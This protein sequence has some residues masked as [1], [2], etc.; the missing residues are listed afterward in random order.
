MNGVVLGWVLIGIGA[1]A[2]LFGVVGGILTMF[3]TIMHPPP[4]KPES[5]GIP[6]LP[7]EFIKVLTEF[8]KT[9]IQA[10]VWLALIIIGIALV[11][12]GGTMIK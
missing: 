4:G 12:W 7:T 9:L 11:A 10:P 5:Y 8:L 3:K 6:G 1:L 2:V